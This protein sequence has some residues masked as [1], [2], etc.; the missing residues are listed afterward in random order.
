VNR[1]W[2]QDFFRD[3]L[4][5]EELHQSNYFMGMVD[6]HT[7]EQ[8]AARTSKQHAAKS[9]QQSEA[10]ADDSQALEETARICRATAELAQEM[11]GKWVEWSA[12]QET[13]TVT[14]GSDTVDYGLL[15]CNDAGQL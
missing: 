3:G 12:M 5:I 2:L 4:T 9:S 15:I 10:A 13:T 11:K 14:F 1:V 6:S 8:L 7:A